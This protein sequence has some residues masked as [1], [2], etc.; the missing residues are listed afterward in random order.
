MTL[1]LLRVSDAAFD[2]IE[3]RLRAAGAD[4]LTA[5]GRLDMNGIALV[6][7]SE[8][9]VAARPAP[10]RR[11]AMPEWRSLYPLRPGRSGVPFPEYD[12]AAQADA[13]LQ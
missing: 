12:R 11:Q 2:E 3:A 9:A 8:H 1:V 7:E 5:H 13:S 10:P 6:R 4:E